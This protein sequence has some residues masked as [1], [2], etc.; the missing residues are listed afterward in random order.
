MGSE[1]RDRDGCENRRCA[2]QAVNAPAGHV[3]KALWI[4]FA[5]H[6]KHGEQHDLN[7]QATHPCK[8]VPIGHQHGSDII[9][10]RQLCSEAQTRNFEERVPHPHEYCQGQQPREKRHT[11]HARRGVPDKE[12]GNGDG[13]G[14]SVEKRMPP[15]QS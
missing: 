10:L 15:P 14:G 1:G 4:A 9:I 12:V 11:F 5:R 8:E 13:D 6:Q 7:G 2:D 3:Q